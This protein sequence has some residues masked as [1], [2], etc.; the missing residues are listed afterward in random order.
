MK[1]LIPFS[2]LLWISQSACRTDE[3]SIKAYN[4][5]PNVSIQ[6]HTDGTSVLDGLPETFY[7]V[8]SDAN[9]TADELS[10][11]WFYGDDL[12]C[13]W[14]IPDEGGGSVCEIT[15]RPQILGAG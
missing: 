15:P 13:D 14:A 5:L 6:S 3:T 7:A 12:V 4:A 8:A 2:L 10:I 11:A 1:T 9:H